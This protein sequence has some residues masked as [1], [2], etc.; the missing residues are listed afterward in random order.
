[1]DKRTELTKYISVSKGII[2]PAAIDAEI[3][4]MAA[5]CPPA[6]AQEQGATDD[7]DKAYIT[8]SI[9]TKS[10]PATQPAGNVSA[11][12]TAPVVEM[13]MEESA[14][15]KRT[16][17][18]QGNNRVAVSESSSI[19]AIVLDRPAPA[20]IIPQG[21]TAVISKEAWDK[22]QAK[23]NAPD[24]YTVLPDDGEEIDADKRIASTSNFEK[25]KAAAAAGTPVDVYVGT[26]STRPIGYL[27]KK[28]TVTGQDQTPE[29][30]TRDEL[31]N[32]VAAA[33][34]GYIVAK[35]NASGVLL[36]KVK[37]GMDAKTHQK[38]ADRVVLAD[39]HKSA[40]PMEVSREVT[41]EKIPATL[42]S[43]LCFRVQYKNKFLKDGVTP[44]TGV[45]RVSLKSEVFK[46]ERK[47][48]Y[49]DKFGTG[50]KNNNKDFLA[51]PDEKQQEKINEAIA[52]QISMMTA[53]A[54]GK[55]NP[56]TKEL[57]EI[58][59]FKTELAAFTGAGAAGANPPA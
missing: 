16:L 30:M 24:G 7:V 46:A 21:T 41:T 23:L 20:E 34:A 49:I 58:D 5:L 35:E 4:K 12:A 14:R 3:A 51:A 2:D 11:I 6:Q 10:V 22:I 31:L 29:Y 39:K 27:V 42:K 53:K 17:V 45:V 13:S 48:K 28:G 56:T 33:T 1:M 44:K 59:K 15:I 43:A 36:R 9:E 55:L 52:L 40:A 19:D 26:Q 25:L 47:T 37:G 38:K 32:W 54:Q 8:M 57:T 50:E 18:S